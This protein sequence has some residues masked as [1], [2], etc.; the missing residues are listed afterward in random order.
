MDLHQQA[1]QYFRSLQDSICNAL[2]ELDGKPYREDN[3][4][5]HQ[6]GG[7]RSRLWLEGNVFEKA[8][9]NFSE[10]EGEFPEEFA[11]TIPGS[12][13][14]FRATGISLVLHPW[15]PHVP[16]VHANF[17]HITKGEGDQ[18]KGWFGGGADLTP[19]YPI[20]EDCVHF[21]QI[22]RDVC[23]Q[24][25]SVVEYQR[26]KKWCDEY[27]FIKHR[28]EPRG[29]GGIFFDYLEEQPEATFE[30]VKAAGDQFVHS[31][32]PIAA[33]RKDMPFSDQERDFQLFR[34]GR[35]VEFNLVYDRGTI[36]GL[37]TGGRTESILMSLPLNVKW[38]YDYHP[39]AGSPEAKLYD[40]LEPRDWA[41][42]DPNSSI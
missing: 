38:L 24:H 21:H 12:G 20:V 39:E 29:I 31:Y 7:G 41:S 13:R 35:Y 30:F 25:G 42:V 36:F 22:W 23:Q 4:D 18:A 6:R 9:V 28:G 10:V 34:R 40:F 32:V 1:A 8:G 17:R 16:T 2:T 5:F 37:K 14:A 3:W 11:A 26:L 15:N 19:Y 27:F 33:K